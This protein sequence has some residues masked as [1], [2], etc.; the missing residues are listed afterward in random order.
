MKKLIVAFVVVLAAAMT[1][2]AAVRWNSGSNKNGF[3]DP[4]GNSL[5]RSDLYTIVVTLYD[6]GMNEL[7][8]G[9]LSTAS[10]LG[11]YAGVSS[12][13]DFAAGGQYYISAVITSKDGKW[14]RIAEAASFTVAADNS[15]P[16]L[17][18][19]TGAGFDTVG[20]KWGSWQAVPE[21]TGA[22]LLVLGVA[23]LALRRKQK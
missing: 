2:A 21:P 3:T 4:T 12:R 10:A 14:E 9:S 18:F 11:A 8:T 5:A 17:N 20:Q 1:Q 19:F 15:D 16:I 7:G 22:M 13:D 6:A 23:A